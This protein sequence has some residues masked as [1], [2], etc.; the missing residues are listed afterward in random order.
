MAL[1]VSEIMNGELFSVGK[2]DAVEM[3][4]RAILTLGITGAPVL[5][6]EGKPLGLV[7]L[8][9]LVGDR[10]GTTVEERMTRPPATV[11]ADARIG[12]AARILARTRYHRLIVVDGDGRAVGMVSAVDIVRGLLGL[13]APHPASFPHVDRESGLSW[14]DEAA[15][16]AEHIPAAPGGPGVLV[17][18]HGGVGV[19]ERP[20]WA[21]APDDVR[22]RLTE[23]LTV[24]QPAA[25]ASWLEYDGIRFRAASVPDSSER[26]DALRAARS[27][28][29]EET[30]RPS[31]VS[32]V[33]RP[34]AG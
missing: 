1:Q 17:L 13:P 16:D 4:L 22:G 14:T 30:R 15:L 24:A 27:L 20:V 6:E 21:E 26:A 10:P 29:E 12:A 32:F 7:S 33:T 5:D 18:Y 2:E 19:P 8:R 9:D 23:M 11:P 28:V 3:A 25:L 31:F 34:L